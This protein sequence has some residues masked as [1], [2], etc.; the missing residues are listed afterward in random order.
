MYG[1]QQE[2]LQSLLYFLFASDGSRS[3]KSGGGGG[4][5]GGHQH[6]LRHRTRSAGLGGRRRRRCLFFCT[7]R[8]R[9]RPRDASEGTVAESRPREQRIREE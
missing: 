1:A 7:T 9:E 8:R 5:G 4:S 2:A 6:D 3:V